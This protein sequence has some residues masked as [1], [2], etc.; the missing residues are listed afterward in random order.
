M[1]S[2]YKQNWYYS[3]H[4]RILDINLKTRTNWENLVHFNFYLVYFHNWTPF[5]IVVLTYVPTW[6]ID[7]LIFNEAWWISMNFQGNCGLLFID[8]TKTW[9]FIMDHSKVNGRLWLWVTDAFEKNILT[10]S[11]NH[12]WNGY[13]RMILLEQFYSWLRDMTYLWFVEENCL[14]ISEFQ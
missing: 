11:M 10:Y 3:S 7:S 13:V 1:Y 12:H 2:V 4:M 6:L 9:V 14:K 8:W 5:H